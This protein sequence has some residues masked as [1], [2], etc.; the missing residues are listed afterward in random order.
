MS[1][2]RH[3]IIVFLCSA[4]FQSVFHAA[5]IEEIV[6]RGNATLQSDWAADP[7]Y[8]YVERDEVLKN[9]KTTSKTSRVVYIAGSDYYLPLAIDDQPLTPD[10]GKAELQKLKN[11]VRRRNAESPAARRQRIAIY[12][13]ERGEN[14]ALVLDFPNAFN[15][16]LLREETMDG[17]LA[18]VLS[19]T[20][21][22]R[23]GVT[24]NAAKV[25]SGMRG[26]VWVDK[27]NF[28]AVRVECDVVT[29]V[30]VYGILAKVLPGTHVG[31]AM[32]PVTDS[33]WLIGEFSMTLKVS[34]FFLFKST[35]ETR[36]T[37]TEY[38]LNQQVLD[39]LLSQ[40]GQ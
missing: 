23:T 3:L 8:A 34:K 26:T 24:S 15:F 25:L 9:E 19:G 31:F 22:K 4:G 21:K 16:E 40:A 35:Q 29:P 14:E 37:Y 28:H 33:V 38:R 18:Y 39:E 10:L 20:P 27:D 36:S 30:P 7:D 11:E 2:H 1:G 6:R 13:K 5:D 32:A 17:H 12:R